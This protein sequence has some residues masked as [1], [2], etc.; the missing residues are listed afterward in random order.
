MPKFT[1]PDEDGTYYEVRFRDQ[2]A[3]RRKG[4][5]ISPEEAYHRSRE[6]N[7]GHIRANRKNR[8]LQRNWND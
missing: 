7:R 1:L 3:S 5:G 8:E 4:N 2:P 6:K